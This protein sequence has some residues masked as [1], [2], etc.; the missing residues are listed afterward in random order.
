MAP[1]THRPDLSAHRRV[2]GEDA[3]E[4]AATWFVFAGLVL[5]AILIFFVYASDPEPR[6]SGASP[7]APSVSALSP[8]PE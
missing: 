1:K 7:V 8:L 2:Y 6:A 5:S 4:F 3:G